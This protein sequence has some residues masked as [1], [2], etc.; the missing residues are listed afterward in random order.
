LGKF[1]RIVT[2]D[3]GIFYG[4][5]VYFA[6]IW[7]ILQ[8]F[9]IFFPFWL[10]A[11]RKIWQSWRRAERPQNQLFLAALKFIEQGCVRFFVPSFRTNFF[12]A[13]RR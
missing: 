9:G 13:G 5:L 1:L 11:P 7:Y 2:E 4:H 12:T 3:V 6:A 8:P 10:V